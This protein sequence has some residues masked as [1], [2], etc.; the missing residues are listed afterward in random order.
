MKLYI[1]FFIILTFSVDSEEE[2]KQGI[3]QADSPNSCA[4]WFQ[5]IITD[6]KENIKS[7]SAAKYVDIEE[8]SRKSH[9]TGE[10]YEVDKAAEELLNA[11]K[12]KQIVKVLD[13][14]NIV[15]YNIKWQENGVDSHSSQEHHQYID[16]L[17]QDFIQKIKDCIEDAIKNRKNSTLDN[18][19]FEEVAQHSICCQQLCSSLYSQTKPLNKIKSYITGEGNSPLV[20]HGQQGSGK[21]SLIAMAA[22]A[23][24]SWVGPEVKVVVR[25]LG[26][27]HHSSK[28]HQLL[29][30]LCLQLCVIFKVDP[31]NVPKVC[32]KTYKFIVIHGNCDCFICS[33]RKGQLA[34]HIVGDL[35]QLQTTAVTRI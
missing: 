2:I 31:T 18:K 7:H 34:H 3:L 25:F 6:I 11:L 27:T 35:W 1:P 20:V 28:V 19:L 12:E 13:K 14:N 33:S 8:I 17:C 29:H 10:P 24:P 22:N 5:R 32:W 26:V 4:F 30:S 9:G 16:K 23:S 21:T 15:S